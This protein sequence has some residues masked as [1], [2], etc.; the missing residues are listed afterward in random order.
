MKKSTYFTSFNELLV[1][2]ICDYLCPGIYN[3]PISM[4]SP[5]SRDNVSTVAAHRILHYLVALRHGP[6]AKAHLQSL[7]MS[8]LYFI[9]I[10]A[11]L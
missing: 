4:H 5:S 7:I 8:L 6:V 11:I 2:S 9:W 1:N 10:P 3:V